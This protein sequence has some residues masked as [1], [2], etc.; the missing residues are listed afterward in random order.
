MKKFIS[1]LLALSSMICVCSS[2]AYA[3]QPDIS[4]NDTIAVDEVNYTTG[5]YEPQTSDN[6]PVKSILS[7]SSKIATCTTKVN[8]TVEGRKCTYIY[9]TLQNYNSKFGYWKDTTEWKKMVPLKAEFTLT[10]LSSSI[11]PSGKYRLKSDVT[12]E[13]SNGTETTRSY[14]SPILTI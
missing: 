4:E 5:E 14:Y 13:M 11:S 2:L 10:N 6:K 3:A 12:I 8:L 9:Q 1:I 7:F